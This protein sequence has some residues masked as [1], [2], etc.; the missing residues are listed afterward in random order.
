MTVG[1]KVY[2]RQ[3]IEVSN[4]IGR[5]PKLLHHK[6]ITQDTD[7]HI[8]YIPPTGYE[9]IVFAVYM[10]EVNHTVQTHIATDESDNDIYTY[11]IWSVDITVTDTGFKIIAVAKN[12]QRVP[13]KIYWGYL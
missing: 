11:N 10:S 9:L 7:E 1:L 6:I 2:N 4:I 13:I 5:Y 12:K 8:S 3:G